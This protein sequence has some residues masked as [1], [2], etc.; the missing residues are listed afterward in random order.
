MSE[1]KFRFKSRELETLNIRVVGSSELTYYWTVQ[2]D[3]SGC[4]EVAATA[5]GDK[6]SEQSISMD[7]QEAVKIA[8][9]I[10]ECAHEELK[11]QAF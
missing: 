4:V 11:K 8:Q 1:D 6:E 9:A 3:S 10:L 7:P 2:I 5:F